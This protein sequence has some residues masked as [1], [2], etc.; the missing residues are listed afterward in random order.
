MASGSHTNPCVPPTYSA[1]W[2]AYVLQINQRY[3]MVWHV[4][5]TH[6]RRGSGRT[7]A[8]E[9]V[10]NCSNR[11][12]CMQKYI[13][14]P[15]HEKVNDRLKSQSSTK[16]CF[17]LLHLP[18]HVAEEC[19]KA[20]AFLATNVVHPGHATWSCNPASHIRRPVCHASFAR[21][22]PGSKGEVNTAQDHKQSNQHE[23]LC[24]G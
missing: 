21:S 6:V 16:G 24:A 23:L 8:N 7:S 9:P 1:S 13:R 20:C 22:M 2:H 11:Q 10:C 3:G 12:P 14:V 5:R 17:T 18:D 4:D 19:I 15:F